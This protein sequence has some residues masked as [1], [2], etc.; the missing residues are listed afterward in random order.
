[1]K[2]ADEKVILVI[3]LVLCHAWQAFCFIPSFFSSRAQK[4]Q[5]D[6]EIRYSLITTD[7][8]SHHGAS[9]ITRL[10]LFEGLKNL[11]S[12]KDSTTQLVEVTI[13]NND[14]IFI[15]LFMKF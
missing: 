15:L 3:L 8:T 5:Y 2:L 11:V 14:V 13:S 7:V 1:M 4:Q 9:S 12:S 10:S 6:T